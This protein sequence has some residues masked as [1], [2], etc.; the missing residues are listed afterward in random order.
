MRV[1]DLTQTFCGIF[2]KAISSYISLLIASKSTLLHNSV[3]N[4][5]GAKHHT[6][7]W[8]WQ[9]SDFQSLPS[10]SLGQWSGNINSNLPQQN[11]L[12]FIAS[13]MLLRYFSDGINDL[14]PE[15]YISMFLVLHKTTNIKLYGSLKY[16]TIKSWTSLGEIWLLYF[17]P[18]K[19]GAFK[20]PTA[21]PEE[22]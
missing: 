6:S 5:Y 21:V 7:L 13:L 14:S 4:T 3:G 16:K 19:C 10:L 11:V 22:Q 12:L 17:T 20:I 15:K 8:K 2:L 18:L 9:K 1:Q